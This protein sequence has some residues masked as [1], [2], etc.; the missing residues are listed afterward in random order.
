MAAFEAAK[1][2]RAPADRLGLIASGVYG[3]AEESCEAEE[4]E[5]AQEAEV[6]PWLLGHGDPLA[7]QVKLRTKAGT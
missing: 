1:L 3:A 5:E 2:L 4:L 7:D 6:V